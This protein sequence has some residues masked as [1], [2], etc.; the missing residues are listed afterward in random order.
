M[1]LHE[2]HLPLAMSCLCLL[3]Q[4]ASARIAAEEAMAAER[5][6]LSL[7]FDVQVEIDLLHTLIVSLRVVGGDGYL[8]AV[9]GEL[10]AVNGCG[11]NRDNGSGLVF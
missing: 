11:G 9:A 5:T 4:G 10:H 6:L 8:P 3:Q 1:R 2:V 7:R